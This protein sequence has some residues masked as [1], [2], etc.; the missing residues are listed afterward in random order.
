MERK[1]D[2]IFK[3]RHVRIRKMDGCKMQP[4]QAHGVVLYAGVK[5]ESA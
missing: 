5:D 4:S 3:E 1:S 2:E